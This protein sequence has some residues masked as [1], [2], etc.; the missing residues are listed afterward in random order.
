MSNDIDPHITE[1][2][3]IKRRLGKGAYGIVWKAMDR[4]STSIVALKK[5]FDAFRNCTDAQR[6][7]REIMFLQEFSNHDNVIKLR[8]VM[9]A[10][11]DRDIYLVFEFMDTDLHAV[12]KKGNI[13]KDI[14]KRYIMYQVLKACNYLHSG[15]VI[16]RDL[17]PSN[18]LLD[19]DC[20]V[21]VCDFGLARSLRQLKETEQGGNPALTEYVATRWYRAPEILLASPRYTKGVDMWSVGCILGE[22]LLGKPLFPGSSTLNQIERIMNVIS[23]PSRADIDSIKSEYGH[24]ILE[25]AS[26]RAKKS[27]GDLLPNVP[28]DALDLVERL[29]VFNPEKR[30]SA[31]ECLS[32]SYVAKF[33]SSRNEITLDYDVLPPLDDDIQLTVAEY[34]NKLYEMILEKK[35]MA[36][37]QRRTTSSQ[38]QMREERHHDS[39]GERRSRNSENPPSEPRKRLSSKNLNSNG[40]YV[41]HHPHHNQS[42]QP[43]QQHHHQQQ[44]QQQQ[45]QHTPHKSNYQQQMQS[46]PYNYHHLAG[47]G[48]RTQ[49]HGSQYQG[50]QHQGSQ[51]HTSQHHGSQYGSHHGGQHHGGQQY[52]STQS[53]RRPPTDHSMY[54]Q[55]HHMQH[56]PGVAFGRTVKYTGHSNNNHHQQKDLQQYR[57]HTANEKK[58]GAETLNERGASLLRRHH[59][60][61][62]YGSRQHSAPS[63]INVGG[64]GGVGRPRSLTQQ[65]NGGYGHKILQRHDNP[66]VNVSRLNPVSRHQSPINSGGYRQ[67]TTATAINNQQHSPLKAGRKAVAGL[68]KNTSSAGSP[69]QRLGSYPQGY[70]VINQSALTAIGVGK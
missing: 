46:S 8:D 40:Q 27:L 66:T 12:I 3:E 44:Q 31:K 26:A 62:G 11:N 10:D 49:H 57:A 60:V 14:H 55:K 1:K 7:F 45:Q 13:L 50:G 59:S 63:Q 18:I 20:F 61:C 47:A 65:Y 16:H 54:Q 22:L 33:H 51:Q 15:N 23:R 34:R 2:Y 21:K 4:H 48:D 53:Q 30:L 25:R 70:S 35:Q 38:D 28:E 52:G 24:S 32:H 68:S 19:S 5:I 17:K 56:Q 36:R 69:K 41:S 29:L 64:G 67:Q 9:K 6:T 37:R 39:S 58:I 43:Q 42:P